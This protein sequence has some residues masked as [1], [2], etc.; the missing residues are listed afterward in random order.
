MFK[1]FYSPSWYRVANLR[2]LFRQHAQIHRHEYWGELWFVLENHAN[3]LYYRITPQ[4][5][6]VIGMMNGQFTMQEIWENASALYGDDAPTQEEVINLMSQLHMTDLLLCDES[7]DTKELFQRYLKIKNNYWKA[8]LGNPLSLRFP[9]FAPEEFLSSSSHLVRPFFSKYGALILLAVLF[10]A[11]VLAGLHWRELTENVVDRVLSTKNL[12]ILWVVFIIIKALHELGHAY[13]INIL[14]GQVPEIGIM[15]LVFMPVPYVDVS[16]SLAFGQKWKRI[17]VGAAG[18]LVEIFIASIALFIWLLLSPGIIRS[19]CYN[20]I[21]VSSISTVLFNANPLL[22]YDGYYILSDLLEI[23]N[24]AQRGSKYIGDLLKRYVFSIKEIVP[25]HTVTGEPFWL[26]SYS[27]C[28]FIYR[29]FLYINIIL[30]VTAKLFIIGILIG[31]WSI[32]SLIAYP[33]YI[34]IK[35]VITGPLFREKRSRAIV[36]SLS[37]ILLIFILLFIVPLPYYTR[38]EGVVWISDDSLVRAKTDGFVNKVIVT[39]NAYVNAGEVLLESRNPLIESDIKVIEAQLKWLK[40][41]YYELV[42]NYDLI[43]SNVIKQEIGDTEGK[44]RRA[45]ER[46][47]NLIVRSPVLGKIILLEGDDLQDRFLKQGDLIAYVLTK[48]VLGIRVIVPQS[49]IDLVRQYNEGVEVRLASQVNRVIPA[50]I[51]RIV[52]GALKSLPSC[53]LGTG[54]GGEIASDPSDKKLLK[55]FDNF[56]QLDLELSQLVECYSIGERVQVRFFH[57]Y[58]PIGHQL[59]RS[60]IQLILRRFNA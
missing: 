1:S 39:S 38:A 41:Q 44:I 33:I 21:F 40:E 32:I 15:L 20:V 9:L 6:Y 60:L 2:P 23:P 49:T 31:I 25:S 54:G 3:G 12:I 29:I 45:L 57:G 18:M 26:I 11:I 8:Q 10:A 24:L 36:V 56:F 34:N 42:S 46:K 58:S 59:Y 5:Y 14:G 35:E 52:P 7:P 13:A 19:L 53:I 43:R 48:N 47:A 28:S 55:S 4:V 51:K 17:L 37:F 22:R 27:I 16:S 50:Y 30:F